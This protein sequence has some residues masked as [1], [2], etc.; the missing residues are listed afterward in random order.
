MAAKG[1]TKT[2]HRQR[3]PALNF[4][5]NG[6]RGVGVNLNLSYMGKAV[7]AEVLANS[8]MH[9]DPYNRASGSGC[10]HVESVKAKTL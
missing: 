10:E 3:T 9:S 5:L 6:G 2:R 7:C 4:A 8:D 1:R